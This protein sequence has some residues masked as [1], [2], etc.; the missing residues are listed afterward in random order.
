MHVIPSPYTIKALKAL[1]LF[2]SIKL[3][4]HLPLHRYVNY[5]LYIVYQ[6]SK[7]M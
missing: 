4:K 7:D 3:F 1:H 2:G 5:K 6:V